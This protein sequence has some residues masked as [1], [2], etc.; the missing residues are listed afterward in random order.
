MSRAIK[1]G[2]CFAYQRGSAEFLQFLNSLVVDQAAFAACTD[3]Y[4][5]LPSLSDLKFRLSDLYA[6]IDSA[7]RTCSNQ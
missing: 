5:L 1:P 7:S 2:A 4:R 3:A 6:G